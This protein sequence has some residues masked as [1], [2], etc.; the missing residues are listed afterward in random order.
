MFK[1]WSGKVLLPFFPRLSIHVGLD[2]SNLTR[3]EERI[4]QYRNDSLTHPRIS[5]T[6]GDALLTEGENLR[7]LEKPFIGTNVFMA[8]GT[9]DILTSFEASKDF[10]ERL[11]VP[12]SCSKTS[13]W[14]EG[15]YHE[16]KQFKIKITY[17]VFSSQRSMCRRSS[18]KLCVVDPENY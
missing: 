13:N 6:T 2:R 10:Y 1:Y 3:I 18:G 17:K 15:G 4:E 5:L 9:A 14:V 7:R 11:A 8:H 16:R 12:E